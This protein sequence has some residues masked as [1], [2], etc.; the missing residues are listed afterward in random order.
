MKKQ[1]AMHPVHQHMQAQTWK[2]CHFANFTTAVHVPSSSV[3]QID[4]DFSSQLTSNDKNISSEA[5]AEL[6]QALPPPTV[7]P[8]LEINIQAIALNVAQSCNLRCT[9]CFAG[10]GDYGKV[11]LMESAVGIEAVKFFSKDQ[12]R[13]HVIFFGGE[14]LLNFKLI[15]SVV[16]FCKTVKT[17][18]FSYSLT[19]N[20][21]LLNDQHMA[22]FKKHGFIMNMSY[23]G[24]GLHAKQRLLANKINNSE[25]MVERKINK[26]KEALS[27]LKSMQ[28]RATVTAKNL[29]YLKD[30]ILATLNSYQFRFLVGYHAT[31]MRE[32][33]FTEEDVNK[34]A[35]ILE[36]VTDD[37]L[38]RGDFE[39]LLR[40]EPLRGHLGRIHK[41]KI[42]QA[43]CGAAIN[44]LSV[45]TVGKFYVC[46]RFTEEEE[47][48]V[49][50][51]TDGLNNSKLNQYLNH[52]QV[53]HKPCNGCWL[54]EWCGGGCFHE[55]K[56]ANKTPFQPDPMFCALQDREMKIA[57]KA[58]GIL[59][60]QKPELLQNLT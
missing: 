15:E 56:A 25:S 5:F 44:Y 40:I 20:G 37:L 55:N 36:Q 24:K 47:Q 50:S 9:Y 31:P 4:Q 35:T 6:E 42:K 17:T 11:S 60:T 32:L 46:H 26:Y 51:I 58:Y 23:D 29:D 13:L 39:T 3:F 41:K 54:R 18:Q 28:L 45:S 8:P 14:P 53:S 27:E 22:F 34:L 21:T 16:E 7:T 2:L 33:A 43:F 59:A 48:H 52:R 19:T 10:D 1:S 57:I 49:G 30:A 38:D 12:K